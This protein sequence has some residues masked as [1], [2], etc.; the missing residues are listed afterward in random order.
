MACK[1]IL[2][3]AYDLVDI[4]TEVLV[5]VVAKNTQAISQLDMRPIC[6]ILLT[7]HINVAVI[8]YSFL[9]KLF[10]TTTI[11]FVNKDK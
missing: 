1:L 3:L 8:S 5:E 9:C 6:Q 10:P 2:P 4:S 7:V 11:M